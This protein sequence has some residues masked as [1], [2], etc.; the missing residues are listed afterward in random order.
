MRRKVSSSEF[1]GA[2]PLFGFKSLTRFERSVMKAEL[3]NEVLHIPGLTNHLRVCTRAHARESTQGRRYGVFGFLP[4]TFNAASLD[5]K[6]RTAGV[7]QGWME[8]EKES[9]RIIVVARTTET[10]DAETA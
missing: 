2:S 8:G 9:L 5:H 10:R 3:R 1:L 4:E 6:E 7:R